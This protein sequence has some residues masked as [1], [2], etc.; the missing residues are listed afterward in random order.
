MSESIN[1][2][3]LHFTCD[4]LIH[5]LLKTCSLFFVFL[6]LMTMTISLHCRFVGFIYG[7]KVA[8]KQCNDIVIVAKSYK[9]G[10]LNLSLFC[11]SLFFSHPLL[12]FTFFINYPVHQKEEKKKK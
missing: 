10:F 2:R 3:K 9:I 8:Q 5:L 6:T 11:G 1:D 4:W 7:K 12:S